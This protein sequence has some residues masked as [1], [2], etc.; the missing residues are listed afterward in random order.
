MMMLFKTLLCDCISFFFRITKKYIF[1]NNLLELI[2]IA[3][4]IS[5]QL[6]VTILKKKQT[7]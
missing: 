5:L 3:K 1:L 7:A 2:P 4:R 6:D